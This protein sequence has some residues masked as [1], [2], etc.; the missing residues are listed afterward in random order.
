MESRYC[1]AALA[2]GFL[3]SVSAQGDA[4]LIVSTVK[5]NTQNAFAGDISNAD[6]VNTG[7]PT[8]ASLVLTNY[9][10]WAGGAS[11]GA[12]INNGAFGAGNNAPDVVM[13]IP[14]NGYEVTFTLNL[15]AGTGGSPLGYD[16]SSIVTF[17]G[18]GDWARN[19]QFYEL[20]YSVVGNPGFVSL[21]SFS[22]GNFPPL[23]MTGSEEA[24]K[25]T[26]TDSTGKIAS[27][28]DAI[29]FIA[30][31][32]YGDAYREFDVFG[33]ATV[34]EPSSISLLTFGILFVCLL[35]RHRRV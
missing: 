15:N 22:S 5:S 9:T 17:A 3:L 35:T 2:A 29:R 27:G 32:N 23:N 33:V 26:F 25:R 11:A 13:E 1:L 21:G 16:I 10:P 4:A 28:V 18:W 34:P 24:T 6:L 20:Q 12:A 7:Q 19:R 8:L 31:D 14:A 30:N